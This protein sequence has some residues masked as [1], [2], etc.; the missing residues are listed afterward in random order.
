MLWCIPIQRGQK[1]LAY[2]W[3]FASYHSCTRMTDSAD[4]KLVRATAHHCSCR[5]Q[6]NSHIWIWTLW[7]FCRK[8]AGLS[9][10]RK[11]FHTLEWDTSNLCSCNAGCSRLRRSVDHNYAR[12][13]VRPQFLRR[14]SIWMTQGHQSAVRS[15]NLQKL[16]F[17]AFLLATR[18]A[19][20]GYSFAPKG[21]FSISLSCQPWFSQP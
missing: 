4:S 18:S 10:E 3:M 14:S 5:F 19:W 15:Q 8:M 6:N 9:L 13:Q 7:T 2:L 20:L 16:V 1:A 17:W 21:H 11:P 12:R